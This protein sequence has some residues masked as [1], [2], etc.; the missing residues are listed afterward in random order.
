MP[1]S[2]SARP[3]P[4]I[5]AL[6]L[7]RDEAD[8][9]A[10]SLDH[11]L[12]W[13]AGVYILDTG[14][15]DGTWEII[16]QRAVREPRIA[17]P[18]R[19]DALFNCGLR[20]RLFNTHRHRFRRGDWIARVDADEF[21]HVNPREFIRDHVR[22]HEGR[23]A[24]WQYLFVVTR[25]EAADWKRG[26]ETPADRARPI[27]ERRR[28][29]LPDPFP[30][31]RFF[32]YRPTMRW[33]APRPDPANPGPMAVERIPVL[34][35]RFRDPDQMRARARLRRQ[36]ASRSPSVGRHWAR[37]R[38]HDL[39]IADD[40]PRLRRWPQGQPLPLLDWPEPKAHLSVTP[41]GRL[42]AACHRLGLAWTLDLLAR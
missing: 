34:H 18:A 27:D 37:E 10:Q 28:F 6:L 1:P 15:T 40:D 5:H 9:I 2:R 38:V 31:Q 36:V 17:T 41:T 21:Y 14:S 30:E 39:L 19:T 12:S 33:I 7:V 3:L 25:R 13:A 24:I 35:Y 8:I 11:L 23:I 16:S 4:A 22:D 26:L 32:R 42:G 20:A 29:F